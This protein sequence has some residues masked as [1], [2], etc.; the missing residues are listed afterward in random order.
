MPAPEPRF[1]VAVDVVALTITD[2]ILQVAAVQRR[3]NTACIDERRDGRVTEVPR[4]RSH[5]WALP[6]GQVEADLE[7]LEAAAR[8]ELREE[9]GIEVAESDLLQIGAYG[10]L[11]RDPRSVRT[12][13]VAFLAFQPSFGGQHRAG[14]DAHHARFLPVLD[15]LAAPNRLE[16]DHERILLDG[17]QRVRDL[18]LTTPVATNFCA[19]Q[20]TITELREVYEVLWH[21][22]YDLETSPAERLKWA[23]EIRG[24]SSSDEVRLL[25]QIGFSSRG[26]ALR[27][28]GVGLTKVF[29]QSLALSSPR[30]TYQLARMDD[31]DL[32]K[33]TRVMLRAARRK[34]PRRPVL[35]KHLDPSNF[36]RKVRDSG[37]ITLVPSA[38]RQTGGE[39]GAGR[40]A[41]LYRAGPA[42]RL[43]PPLRLTV[44]K[45]RPTGESP[46]RRPSP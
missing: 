16:F 23:T 42:V 21:E 30:M 22:A 41:R 43:D 1:L 35:R 4:H 36:F 15:L 33:M 19:E 46:R 28:A 45:P 11:G 40:P 5:H 10:D 18:M 3:A 34:A 24:W 37:L 9:T 14:S 6:G 7:G 39:E 26:A 31:E 17:I 25:D 27:E 44:K 29:S 20:F 12:V 8:R 38:T 32:Q 2:G 13:S